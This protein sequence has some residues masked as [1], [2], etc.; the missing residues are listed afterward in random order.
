MLKTFLHGTLLYVVSLRFPS[1]I[2]IPTQPTPENDWIQI[3]SRK[4]NSER[5]RMF[6]LKMCQISGCYWVILIKI[7]YTVICPIINSYTG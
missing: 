7:C 1:F 2:F 6:L 3:S 4:S 5:Y